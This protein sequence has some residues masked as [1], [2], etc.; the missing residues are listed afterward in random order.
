MIYKEMKV[1]LYSNILHELKRVHHEGR[2]GLCI[3]GLLITDT[4]CFGVLEMCAGFLPQSLLLS[5]LAAKR[6]VP[7]LRDVFTQ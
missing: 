1:Q 6:Q 4:E 5:G 7:H 2:S 3:L